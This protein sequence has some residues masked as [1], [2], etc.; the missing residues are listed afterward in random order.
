MK[1]HFYISFFKI[2]RIGLVLFLLKMILCSCSKD[3]NKGS[4]ISQSEN[5]KQV[6][7]EK[8]ENF[9]DSVFFKKA[10][11]L[12]SAN[13]TL[14]DS[15]NIAFGK[16]FWGMN[17][18]EVNQLNKKIQKLGKYSY[19]FSYSYNSEGKLYSIYIFSNPE[20]VISYEAIGAKYYNLYNIVS[21]KYGRPSGPKA[22]PSIFDVMNA[23]TYWIN[24]W[25]NGNKEIKLGIRERK[26][27]SY[28]VLCKITNLKMNE[29]ELSHRYKIKNK[30]V[31]KASE[32]F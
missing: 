30:D 29:E 19:S 8:S 13:A 21:I 2:G 10:S 18:S 15:S 27:D 17:Q 26:L 28:E 1:E 3:N 4:S 12:D 16:V 23:G 20:Q 6:S 5:S 25:N 11:K 7:V 24:K 9:K 31:L 14:S 22:V 32:K